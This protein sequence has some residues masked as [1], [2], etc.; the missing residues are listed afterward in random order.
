MELF[1]SSEGISSTYINFT[2]LKIFVLHLLEKDGLCYRTN[3][4]KLCN[5]SSL[6][7]PFP[8]FGFLLM[9]SSSLYTH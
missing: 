9:S 1:P 8:W 2:K 5:S 6:T 3:L 7:L 4:E